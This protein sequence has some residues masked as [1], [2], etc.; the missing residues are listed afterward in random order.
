MLIIVIILN[1]NSIYKHNFS[2]ITVI[3]IIYTELEL[4]RIDSAVMVICTMKSAGMITRKEN[5]LY[6]YYYHHTR[7]P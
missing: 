5:E 6:Y 7:P 3:K 1:C 2:V 4:A